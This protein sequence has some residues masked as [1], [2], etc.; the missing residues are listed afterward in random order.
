MVVKLRV[1]LS[2]ESIRGAS[3]SEYSEIHQTA[4]VPFTLPDVKPPDGD[5][6]QSCNA[7]KSSYFKMLG[8]ER[9]WRLLYFNSFLS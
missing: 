2:Q 9:N 1:L 3:A 5:E 7:L 8:L 6:G 4:T